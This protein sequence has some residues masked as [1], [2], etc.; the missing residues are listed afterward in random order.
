MNVDVRVTLVMWVNVFPDL[1]QMYKKHKRD[2]DKKKNNSKNCTRRWIQKKKYLLVLAL[3]SLR[4]DAVRIII[5]FIPQ[6]EALP[7]YPIDKQ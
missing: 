6:K 4:A 5:M 2:D 3:L 7:F 1:P